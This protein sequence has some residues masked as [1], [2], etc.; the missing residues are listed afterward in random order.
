MLGYLAIQN[1]E[2]FAQFSAQLLQ[3]CSHRLLGIA[4]RQLTLRIASAT[5]VREHAARAG[6]RKFLIVKQALDL[7]HQF[8]IALAIKPLSRAT[9][10][11]LQL[12]KFRLPKAQHV[13]WQRAQASYVANAEVKLVWNRYAGLRLVR[14]ASRWLLHGHIGHYPSQGRWAKKK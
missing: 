7:K 8:H 3:A 11:W 14:L 4:K 9:L 5:L 6:N 13:R 2:N 10:V 12:R 1:S